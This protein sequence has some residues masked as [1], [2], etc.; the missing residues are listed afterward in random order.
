MQRQP[1]A[2]AASIIPGYTTPEQVAAQVDPGCQ[3]EYLRDFPA[4]AQFTGLR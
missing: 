2:L 4:A 3:V 1:G